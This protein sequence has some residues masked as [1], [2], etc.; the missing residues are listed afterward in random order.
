MCCGMSEIVVNGARVHYEDTGTALRGTIVFAHGLLWAGW[1]FDAQVSALLDRYRCIRFDFRGQG[2]SEVTPSGYDMETLSS[3]AAAIIDRLQLGPVHFVGLS[4]GGFIGMRLAARNPELIRS[5]ILI[6]T[7]ADPEPAENVPKFRKLAFIARWF[8]LRIIAGKIMPILFGKTFLSDPSRAADR[9]KYLQL[10]VRNHRIG[11]TRA[12]HGVIDRKGIY[13][14]IA[15]ITA[16]TL[17]MVGEEDV[18]TVPAKAERIAARIPGAN[19]LRIPRAGH[20]S[21][22]EEPAAVTAAI[23]SFL[24]ER[25]TIAQFSTRQSH[26]TL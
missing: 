26:C 10:L 16:P 17:I 21:S 11:I 9:T 13:D 8:G 4:M 3:D 6:E 19:L 24:S 22:I 25:W 2:R 14:E 23:E 15:S 5:L 20:S 1:M 18:A 7:T 12:V